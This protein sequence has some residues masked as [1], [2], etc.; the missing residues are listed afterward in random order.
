M[1]GRLVLLLIGLSMIAIA[2]QS[3]PFELTPRMDSLL[4]ETSEAENQFSPQGPGNPF[5]IVPPPP[6]RASNDYE[7]PPPG[8]VLQET[9]MG[10]S[11]SF[12]VLVSIIDF[13]LLTILVVLFRN[14]FVRVYN[15]FVN[16]NLLGQLY[17]ERATGL[18]IPFLSLYSLYFFNLGWLVF[19][20]LKFFKAD[21]PYSDSR[22]LL[23]C[24]FGVMVITILRHLVL[25]FIAFAFPVD[26]EA[27]LYSFS[28][29]IF[30]VVVGVI[31]IPVNLF[32]AMAPGNLSRGVLYIGFVVVI[33]LYLF[34]SIRG[35]LIANR[36]LTFYKFHF[37]L[38][39]CTVEIAP[40]VVLYKLIS[41]YL[42]A[43]PDD[44]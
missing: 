37:L 38:Y 4:I 34:R 9:K 2:Q 6:G 1:K 7:V 17:R 14:Y 31:L 27:R 29:N 30:N 11:R 20:A 16:D 25:S 13:V 28:I 10:S 32:V 12:L 19:L 18:G 39:I 40:L 43:I 3:N 36:Y 15:G 23:L 41:I 42:F 5:D 44:L 24:M 35:L 8:P 33:L 22:L 26:N 21:L